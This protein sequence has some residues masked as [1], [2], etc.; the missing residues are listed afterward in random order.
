MT[1]PAPTGQF[2]SGSDSPSKSDAFDRSLHAAVARYT[3]GLS[4]IALSQAWW[5]WAAHLSSS[6]G[7][8]ADLL[9]SAVTKSA[10]VLSGPAAGGY[11]EKAGQDVRFD[12][13]AWR[14]WPFSF[15][16][17]AHK[18][19]EE[20]WAEAVAGLRGQ[21]VDH[22]KVNA[23]AVRQMLDLASPSN[24]MATNPEVQR[25][26]LREA[27]RNLVRGGRHF[28]EDLEHL[29]SGEPAPDLSAF[30]V[31]ETVAAT[32]GDVVFRNHLIE[33]IR[34]APT[35]DTV[36]PEP[37]LLIP[38]WIMKF[39]ILD[40]SPHNS[41]VRFLVGQGHTVYCISWRNPDAEDRDLGMDDYLSSGIMAALDA[42]EEDRPDTRVHAVGYCLGGTLL[43]IAAAAMGRDGDDR[44]ATVSLLAAQADFTEAGELSLFIN[45]SQL[46]LL[47]DMMWKEGVLKAEQ[48]AGTFQLL[49]S[50]DLIWSRVLRDYMMGQ[51]SEPN[52]L[53]AWNADTTRMPYRMHSEY[54][55][56]LYLNNDLAEE[57]LD[58]GGKPVALSD[59]RVPVFA[60]GTERDHVAPWKSA[61]K[62]QSMSDAEVTFALASGG[63]NGGIVS[64]PGHPR[65]HFRI[66]TTAEHA[67]HV[68]P[69]EWLKLAEQRDGSWWTA[70]AEWLDAR[71][72]AKIKRP[73]MNLASVC[74]APGTYV[75]QD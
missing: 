15:W 18:A 9:A 25:Q 5:D 55:R 50:N 70:W 59:I 73:V 57:R 30:V 10:A 13:D 37:I 45:D 14:T 29:S 43:S 1:K 33:L 65:R 53:M 72:L 54:L 28:L 63:H 47:E 31:G 42:I 24:Y 41:M 21:S 69:E 58:V 71:S 12:D 11:A 64:E 67:G 16:A 4:P 2:R 32:P 40:L 35:T 74:P 62:I 23:F 20:W 52:D 68:G 38:A 8:R 6:P 22:E 36:H 75:F 48:M 60:V 49:K 39:Y 26:T 44:L 46:A 51:R 17:A 56:R 61:Y 7:R 27:G 34:Y 3:A 19:Q 66:H